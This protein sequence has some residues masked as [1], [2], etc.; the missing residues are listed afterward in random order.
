LKSLRVSDSFRDFALDQLA[1]VPDLRARAMF[2]GIGVY[3]GDVFFG[4]LAADVLYFKV[5]DENRQA[6]EAAGSRPFTPFDNRT[7]TMPYWNVPAA[8]LEDAD[9]LG[10]WARQSIAVA[11][12]AR[13]SSS[14]RKRTR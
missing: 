4:I 3:A 6:Y 7:M 2:G 9:A 5:G 1:G 11:Q 14:N 10:T 13:G 12:G 8:V